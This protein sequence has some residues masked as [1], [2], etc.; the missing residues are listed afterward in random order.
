MHS[1]LLGGQAMEGVRLLEA[2]ELLSLNL[3]ACLA[4]GEGLLCLLLHVILQL[5]ALGV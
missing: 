2:M 5:D 1:Q 3:P 4:G